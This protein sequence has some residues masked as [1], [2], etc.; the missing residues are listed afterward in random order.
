MSDVSK[1]LAK[2]ME[3]NPRLQSYLDMCSKRRA[4]IMKNQGLTHE[5]VELRKFNLKDLLDASGIDLES[6]VKEGQATAAVKI[7]QKARMEAMHK[8]AEWCENARGLLPF[9]F[10]LDFHYGRP[11]IGIVAAPDAD[12]AKHL[13][14]ARAYQECNTLR[15]NTGYEIDP[16]TIE[17]RVDK[18]QVDD[19]LWVGPVTF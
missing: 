13:V 4:M 11:L 6:C 17:V 1:D 7:Q 2:A 12:A 16:A 15:A 9:K 18:L 14:M 5:Q 10:I 3:D 19:F 8:W